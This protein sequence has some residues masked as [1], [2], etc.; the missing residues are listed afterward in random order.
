MRWNLQ[1]YHLLRDPSRRI[2]LVASGRV[3]DGVT[4]VAVVPRP[5]QF[6]TCSINVHKNKHSK[7]NMHHM[8]T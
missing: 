4:F 3:F 8:L 2:D 5:F 1:F 6:G 7:I